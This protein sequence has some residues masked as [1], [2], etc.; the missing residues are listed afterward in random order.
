MKVLKRMKARLFAIDMSAEPA[1]SKTKL[2]AHARSNGFGRGG[3]KGLST[4]G[5]M[6]HPM[7]TCTTNKE[8]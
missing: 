6:K 8:K 7:P 3:T 1:K 4:T 2:A 5:P